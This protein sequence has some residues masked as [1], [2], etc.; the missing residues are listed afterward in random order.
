MHFLNVKQKQVRS[1]NKSTNSADAIGFENMK[2]FH[3]VKKTGELLK[4]Q[5]ILTVRDLKK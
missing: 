4:N 2:I 3:S 5:H 1:I